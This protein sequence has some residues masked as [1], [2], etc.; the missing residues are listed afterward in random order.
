[1]SRHVRAMTI[2][3]DPVPPKDEPTDAELDTTPAASD[4]HLVDHAHAHAGPAAA[5]AALLSDTSQLRLQ[6]QP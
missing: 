3:D 6:S 1:M 5:L 4:A 2:S